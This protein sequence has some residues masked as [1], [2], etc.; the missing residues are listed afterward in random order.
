LEGTAIAED[1]ALVEDFGLPKQ[2][3]EFFNCS[4]LL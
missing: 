4:R 3:W 2:L 1:N